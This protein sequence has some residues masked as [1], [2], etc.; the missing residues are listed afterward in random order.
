MV[1]IFERTIGW[2]FLEGVGRAH[3]KLVSVVLEGVISFPVSGHVEHVAAHC[4][5]LLH[6]GEAGCHRH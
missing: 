2:V 5:G 4:L 6:E 3:D 1:V